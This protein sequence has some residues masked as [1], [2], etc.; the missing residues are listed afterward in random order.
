MDISNSSRVRIAS[1]IYTETF[2]R[3]QEFSNIAPARL[4]AVNQLGFIDV[5][6]NTL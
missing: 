5:Q 3:W 1:I 6:V 4:T 2:D